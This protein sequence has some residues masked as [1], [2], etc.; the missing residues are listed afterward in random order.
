[1]LIRAIRFSYP[2]SSLLI[3]G[4]I[5]ALCILAFTARADDPADPVLNLLL[6]KGILTQAE[7][8]KAKAEAERI[9]TN[10]FANLMPPV[11]SKWKI[12]KGIQNIELFGDLR[13]RYEHR[14]A[15]VP[16]NE[17]LELDRGRYSLR[18]GLRGQAF[19][20]FYYGLR[21]D[22]APNPRSPWVT[23]GTSSSGVPN[24]GPFGKS[25][26]GINVGL[27]YIGWHPL[28]SVDVTV[29][30]MEQPLYTTPMVWDSDF[31]PEGAAEKFKVKVGDATFFA[32]FGQ[33]LYQDMN[34]S[35]ASG[36]LGFNGFLGEKN[37]LIFQIAWQGGV[38][39]KLTTNL[40]A[41]LAATF[42][43]YV[44]LKQSTM[45]P[46]TT[47]PPFYGDVYIGE[48]AYAGPDSPQGP[49]GAGYLL[50]GQTV[51]GSIAYP[52]FAYPLNQNGLRHLQVVELPFELNY[53]TAHFNWRLFGDFSY[54]LDGGKRAEEAAQAYAAFLVNPSSF[55]TAL[56]VSSSGI[57]PFAPQRQDVKAY[58]VGLGVGSA[59]VEYGPTRGVVYGNSSKKHAWEVRTYW[60]HV[61]QYALDP[62]LLDSDFFE[63]RANLEGIYAAIGYGFSANVIGE[64]RYGYAWRINEL[65]GTGGSNQDIPQLNPIDHYSILQLDLTM[66]F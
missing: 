8:D 36:G 21:L 66:R 31:N 30:K 20:D 19:D 49:G 26:A 32:N 42:Y 53:R 28:E 22:T 48:G 47:A 44:G 34:P 51:Q 65:L 57:K 54:N 59:G 15:T 25:T 1:V 9:R 10:E 2:C 45:S 38:D 52:S 50:G 5:L 6:Q 33:F 12:S 16:G 7:V 40:S 17:R 13:L 37:D 3:D 27:I 61:E 11:E 55:N 64:V 63:G 23:F 58:Q 46:P 35:Y 39:L 4:L 24:Q 56:P 43:Q 29:G 41:K 60:Q 14:E 62:N 18:L